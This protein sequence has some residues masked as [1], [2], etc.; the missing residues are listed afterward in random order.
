METHNHLRLQMI[1]LGPLGEWANPANSLCF[2]FPGRGQAQ[3][4]SG[5]EEHPLARGDVAVVAGSSGAKLHVPSGGEV[6][7]R[8]FSCCPEHLYQV[9]GVREIPLLQNLG[10]CFRKLVVYPASSA[11]ALECHR[12]IQQTPREVDLT[13]RSHLLRVAAE[14]VSG[15][16]QDVRAGRCGFI[17]ME[18]HLA[19]VLD[20]L[21]VDDVLNHSIT[22]LAERFGCSRRHLNRLFH[23]FFG[24]SAN[25][26]RMEMRLLKATALLRDPD[27][28]VIHVAEQTGFN[29][30]GL[31]NTCFKRRFGI[32]PREWRGAAPEAG[33]PQQA[34]LRG[35]PNCGMR[36][37][38][39][40]PW[41]GQGPTDWVGN[42]PGSRAGNRGQ[43]PDPKDS[44]RR[45]A[46][47]GKP[48]RPGDLPKPLEAGAGC[49]SRTGASAQR[50]SAAPQAPESPDARV[51]VEPLVASGPGRELKFRVVVGAEGRPGDPH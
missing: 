22:E 33:E 32:S 39:L 19:R 18:E 28:K 14:I 1:R 34:P 11:L 5:S 36:A 21:T 8:S 40:C 17:R 9:C 30:L 23:E 15:K 13:H 42:K 45:P 10:E 31:F 46:L 41:A 26:L 25:G 44:G 43:A 27:V 51:R 16:I 20:G 6:E 29:H 4:S 37:R 35:D 2:L 3:Y 24:V 50:A 47:T 38:G 12:L 49:P 7:I 48:G